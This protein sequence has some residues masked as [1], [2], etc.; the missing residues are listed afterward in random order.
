MKTPKHSLRKIVSFL[1]N[2]DE[3]GGLW[4]PNI[5][6]PLVW[7]EDQICHFNE[8]SQLWF[9]FPVAFGDGK[10]GTF[11]DRRS[12]GLLLSEGHSDNFAC[13]LSPTNPSDARCS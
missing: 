11:S 1:S 8:P 12:Q 13:I 4:L 7:G 5:Q 3:D 6:R 10:E 9:V 2:P